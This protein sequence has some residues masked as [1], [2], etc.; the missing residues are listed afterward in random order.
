MLMRGVVAAL[1]AIVVGMTVIGVL[2]GRFN[3][4]ASHP[5][6]LYWIVEQ[7][8]K[9]GLYAQFCIPVP[10]AELPPVDMVYVTPCTADTNGHPVIKQIIHIDLELNAYTVTGDHPRSLDT[11]VFGTLKRG[12]ITGVL[13][14]VWTV[15]AEYSDNHKSQ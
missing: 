4:T 3:R 9:V 13:S 14:P 15:T 10:I 12:D 11:R 6:G 2:G 5:I 8:P 1:A 7:D